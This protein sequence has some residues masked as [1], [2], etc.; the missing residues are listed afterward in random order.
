VSKV[1]ISCYAI[2]NNCLSFF[3]DLALDKAVFVTSIL[4]RIF[5]MVVQTNTCVIKNRI[6][7]NKLMKNQL[8]RQIF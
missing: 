3:Y 2:L 8:V 4:M 7:Y 6:Q 1:P 5:E